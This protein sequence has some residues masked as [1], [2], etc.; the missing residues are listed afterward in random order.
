MKQNLSIYYLSFIIVA[1]FFSCKDDENDMQ[2]WPDEKKTEYINGWIYKNMSDW[3]YWNDFLPGTVDKTKKPEDFFNSLLYNPDTRDGDRFSWLQENYVD[4]LNALSGY[5]PSEMGFEYQ[6]VQYEENGP[7]YAKVLYVKRSTEAERKGLK[8]GMEIA[9]V[10]GEG[11]TEGNYNSVL[12]T[13]LSYYR[14]GILD[15]NGQTK[16]I[17]FQPDKEYAENPIYLDSIYEYGSKKVGY[18]VY[19][20]F[21]RGKNNQGYEYDK[22]LAR[23]LTEFKNSGVNNLILDL[24]YNG[25]G[26]VSSSAC[27]ASALV[28][29]RNTKNI[30][31]NY[32]YNTVISKKLKESQKHEYFRD[33]VDSY[34]IPQLGDQL[35]NLY[36]ITTKRSASASELVINGLNS[37]M[38]SKIIQIGETTY[39][40]NVASQTFIE[41]NK[42][43]KEINKCGLQPIV[44]KLSNAN[45]FS[46]Y[47]DG[48]IPDHRINELWLPMDELGDK[49]EVLLN[50]ALELITGQ[51]S[52]GKKMRPVRTVIEKYT[53]D[54]MNYNMYIDSDKFDGLI[55]TE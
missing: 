49:N 9:T 29:S 28:P 50:K 18:L 27:L 41:E 48:F 35:Q 34:Q 6:F 3:Y 13:N 51:S 17:E 53:P 15:E 20:F 43:Y 46:D 19:N 42:K 52:T 25:G 38:E 11:M 2:D 40:K 12:R 37:F 1:L 45:G 5:S 16:I 44:A 31:A 33:K 47:V 30:F 10:N 4:L 54:K 22:Q 32:E 26:A 24:R 21:A 7:I 39:G 23:I 14:L 8:R 55:T 36:V